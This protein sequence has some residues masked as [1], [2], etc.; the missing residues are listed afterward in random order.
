VGWLASGGAL[1]DRWANRPGTAQLW[2]GSRGLVVDEEPVGQFGFEVGDAFVEEAVVVAGSLQSLL[3]P[4]LVL[5]E[6][7][8]LLV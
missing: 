8:G 1:G 4:V 6:L 3:Q 2:A 5:D 7:A